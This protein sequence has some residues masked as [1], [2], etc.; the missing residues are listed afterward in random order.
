[1]F[2]E[3]KRTSLLTGDW[4]L[5]EQGRDGWH[6]VAFP[7]H[8]AVM[9]EGES[10]W[11][12]AEREEDGWF[13]SRFVMALAYCAPPSIAQAPSAPRSNGLKLLWSAP[14]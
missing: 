4:L 9:V 1:M 7:D 14:L 3:V 12:E 8:L 11:F 13:V 5:R 2:V 10:A 6:L